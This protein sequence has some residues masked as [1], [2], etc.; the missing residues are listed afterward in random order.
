MA[1]FITGTISQYTLTKTPTALPAPPVVFATVGVAV[2]VLGAGAAGA[3]AAEVKSAYAR[4][5]KGFY[6][7]QLH[8]GRHLYPLRDKRIREDPKILERL[9]ERHPNCPAIKFIDSHVGYLAIKENFQAPYDSYGIPR[10]Q[11]LTAQAAY[12]KGRYGIV[13]EVTTVVKLDDLMVRLLKEYDKK[14]K[15]VGIILAPDEDEKAHVLPLLLFFGESEIECLLADCTGT[16]GEDQ[17]SFG[18]LGKEILR[19]HNCKLLWTKEA[20]QADTFSCRLEAI[21]F[22]RNALLFFRHHS[23]K[24][25]LEKTLSEYGKVEYRTIDFVP[26]QWIHHAQI[27]SKRP[28]AH[29]ELVITDLFNEKRKANPRTIEEFHKRYRQDFTIACSFYLKD[30]CNNAEI[31]KEVMNRT[32]KLNNLGPHVKWVKRILPHQWP[33]TLYDPVVIMSF[34][35]KLNV[36]LQ[37]RGMREAGLPLPALV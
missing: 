9:R 21:L 18:R 30:G 20:R 33:N 14:N 17:Y 16:Y 12:Y 29:K 5:L 1:A 34:K 37:R 35:G 10:I 4:P 25:G 19:K 13:I 27:F 28:N 31:I 15:Y 24:L 11:W 8:A 7:S 36:F 3:A 22:L 23:T 6:A 2:P 26:P 32:M